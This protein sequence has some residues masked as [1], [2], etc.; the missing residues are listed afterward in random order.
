MLIR[1][2]GN[3]AV[4]STFS[5]MLPC[6]RNLFALQTAIVRVAIQSVAFGRADVATT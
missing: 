5:K 2:Y 3:R 6:G 4:T 1:L